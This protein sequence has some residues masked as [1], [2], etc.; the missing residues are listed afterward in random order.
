MKEVDKIYTVAGKVGLAPSAVK[1]EEDPLTAPPAQLSCESHN[2]GRVRG[3]KRPRQPSP[4]SSSSSSSITRTSSDEVDEVNL[5]G[6]SRKRRSKGQRRARG[7]PH[8]RGGGGGTTKG[9]V[10]QMEKQIEVKG[11]G[12][13]RPKGGDGRGGGTLCEWAIAFLLNGH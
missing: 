13:V 11:P 4:T 1:A 5:T 3:Q 10:V 12:G 6:E 8:E 7:M 2:E 9:V